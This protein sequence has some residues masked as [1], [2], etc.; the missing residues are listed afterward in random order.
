[1]KL[2]IGEVVMIKK[3]LEGGKYYDDCFFSPKMEK[4]CGK[5]ATIIEYW[6]R[7]RYLLDIDKKRWHWSDGMLERY[8]EVD[9]RE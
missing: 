7:E 3:E 4:Y 8:I 1:M 9:E 6:P 5:I 2:K